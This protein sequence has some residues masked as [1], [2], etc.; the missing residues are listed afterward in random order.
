MADRTP[1]EDDRGVVGAA[2]KVFAIPEL[3]E[4]VLQHLHLQHPLQLFPLRR[5]NSTF[6][7]AIKDSKALRVYYM[8]QSPSSDP[9]STTILRY[10]PPIILNKLWYP[11]VLDSVRDI[12]YGS[13]ANAWHRNMNQD[14]QV[15]TSQL[16]DQ[17]MNAK[18]SW[19]DIVL[20]EDDGTIGRFLIKYFKEGPSWHAIPIEKGATMGWFVNYYMAKLQQD[21]AG[22]EEG[23]HA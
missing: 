23:T 15:Y 12:L 16:K 13:L 8:S 3:L 14:L 10:S 21:V 17:P 2:T 9:N 22:P 5:V 19:R 20:T 18:A 7:A 6:H 11:L 1:A 4:I